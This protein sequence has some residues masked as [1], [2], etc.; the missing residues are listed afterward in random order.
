[1]LSVFRAHQYT[2]PTQS[3]IMK[4]KKSPEPP[5]EPFMRPREIEAIRN[6]TRSLL[7]ELD[8]DD[9]IEETA[10]QAGPQVIRIDENGCRKI[11]HPDGSEFYYL[12]DD[13]D[14]DMPENDAP[15]D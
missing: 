7:P 4:L 6:E 14:D 10:S 8:E 1:N 11:V 3:P 13:D 5:F 9:I 12:E 15:A 2:P